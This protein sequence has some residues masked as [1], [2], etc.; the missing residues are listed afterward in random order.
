MTRLADGSLRIYLVTTNYSTGR[1]HRVTT[2]SA[3]LK[4][5]WSHITF[6]W[7]GGLTSSSLKIYVNG[8]EASYGTS[9][10]GGTFTGLAS[11]ANPTLIGARN[12]TST[13]NFGS[14][15]TGSIDDVR[16][17]SKELSVAEVKQLYSLG[18]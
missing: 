9:D 14:F 1:I 5:Q 6:T 16:F 18:R 4:N 10:N 8:V 17:Y 11:T 2:A 7:S 13:S 3:V 15:F 12:N